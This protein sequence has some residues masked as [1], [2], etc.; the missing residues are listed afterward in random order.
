MI[1]QYPA[2]KVLA[3]SA[4]AIN[5]GVVHVMN[6]TDCTLAD[7]IQMASSNP[8][9]LYGLTDRGIMAPGKRADLILI[10]IGEKEINIQINYE[11]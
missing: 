8:A 2:Q 10:T 3:G 9:I 6:V 11:N 4:S 1:V 7:A 5:R